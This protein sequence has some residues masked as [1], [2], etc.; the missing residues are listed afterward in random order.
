MFLTK[1]PIC[2][3]VIQSKDETDVLDLC[4]CPACGFDFTSNRCSNPDCRKHLSRNVNF[5]Q[6]CGYES[7]FYLN[8]YEIRTT[9]VDDED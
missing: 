9:F 2:D 7:T 5:C 6:L 1:C 8:A 3:H 4:Y